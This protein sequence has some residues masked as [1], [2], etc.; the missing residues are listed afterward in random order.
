MGKNVDKM[1]FRAK[2]QCKNLHLPDLS[3]KTSRSK[4][5]LIDKTLIQAKMHCKKGQIA[6]LSLEAIPTRTIIAPAATYMAL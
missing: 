5:E 4:L 2:M 1:H 3:T 6:L